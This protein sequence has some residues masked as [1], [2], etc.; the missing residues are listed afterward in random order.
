MSIYL[1]IALLTGS[2]GV[3]EIFTNFRKLFNQ[4]HWWVF[5]SLICFLFIFVGF[6]ECG[7]DYNNYEAYFTTLHSPFW[8]EN[9]TVV[10]VEKGYAYVNYI[11]GSYQGLLFG[12]AVISIVLQLCFIYRYSPLPVLQ[13]S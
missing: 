10:G 8:K 11:A 7:F 9:A 4:F 2:L 1:F 12:I 3:L 6:R 5:T 13:Y